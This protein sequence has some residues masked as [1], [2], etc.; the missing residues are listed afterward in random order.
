MEDLSSCIPKE[1]LIK[2]DENGKAVILYYNLPLSTCFDAA[3][4]I[5]MDFA[6]EFFKK[7][8]KPPNAIAVFQ[9]LQELSHEKLVETLIMDKSVIQNYKIFETGG[10]QDQARYNMV[11]NTVLADAPLFNGSTM[12][13]S[14]DFIAKK[15]EAGYMPIAVMRFS[16][17]PDMIFQSQVNRIPPFLGLVFH[18]RVCTHLGDVGAGPVVSTFSLLPGEITRI[19]LKHYLSD[20]STTIRS[21]NILDSFSVESA[22]EFEIFVSNESA[23][24]NGASSSVSESDSSNWNSGGSGGINL[25]IFSI[26]GG[27]G[28]GGSSSSSSSSSSYMNMHA[29]TLRN[30][31]SR[32]AQRSNS[33]RQISVNSTSIA[34]KTETQEDVIVRNLNNINSSRVLNFVFRQIL[35]EFYTITYLNDVSLLFWDGFQYKMVKLSQMDD[36]LNPIF[37]DPAKIEKVKE[38]IVANLSSI[39]DYE[40]NRMSFIECVK[41][42]LYS[43]LDC[44]CIKDIKPRNVCYIRKRKDLSQTYRDTTVKG[45]ILDVTSRVFRTPSVVVE[46]LLGQGE[47]LDCFNQTQKTGE[48]SMGKLQYATVAQAIKII[49]DIVGPVKKARLYKKVFGK[50]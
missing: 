50:D 25:G 12:P 28:G 47:A 10:L 32:Q 43:K 48:A 1:P 4:V 35:Q 8:S 11:K 5:K 36:L 6:P 2:L 16:G 3:G 30:A 17:V 20:S 44:E 40:G 29:S 42:E 38:E 37:N 45:I 31:L 22:T 23:F 18:Y 39:Y 24:S 49:D 14:A 9:K 46:A 26:G 27:G 33:F 21:Q 19:C 13:Y 15:I 7:D 41:E 34:S